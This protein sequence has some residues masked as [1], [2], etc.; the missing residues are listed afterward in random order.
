[1]RAVIQRVTSANVAIDGEV[2][3][4]IGRGFLILLGV[5]QDD[6]ADQLERLWSKI[7]KMRIF[8]DEEGKTNLSLADVNGEVLVVSQFTLY[9]NCRKG[10]RPSFTQAGAPDEANRLYEEFVARARQDVPR[11]ETGRFGADMQVSLVNDGPF[12]IVLDTADLM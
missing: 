8:S 12:T 9:A 7:Y 5:G 11:V 10:N 3:G 2:V 4:S 1:M 6:G